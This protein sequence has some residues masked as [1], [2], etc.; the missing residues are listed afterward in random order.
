MEFDEK[1][2]DKNIAELSKVYDLIFTANVNVA[3]ISSALIDGLKVVQRRAIYS[4]YL[5]DQGKKYRKLATISGDTTGSFHPHAPTSVTDAVVGMAQDWRNS[6]PLVDGF[7]NYGSVG[8]DRAGADRYITARL[9]EYAIACFFEDW[10]DS[11]VDMELGFDEETYIPINFPAKYPN[12]LLNGCKGIGHMG[13]SC[14][15]PCFNFR[16]VVE[17]T[18]QLMNNPNSHIALIPDSPTGADIIQ[19]DF[20]KLCETGRGSYMQRCTYEI[21]DNINTITITSLPEGVFSNSVREKIADIKEKGGLNELTGMDDLTKDNVEIVLTV[22]SDVNPYKFIKKLI[23]EIPGLQQTYPIV[24]TVSNDYQTFDWSIKQLIIEWIKW[25]REQK[26]VVISNKRASLI[27]DQRTNDVKL[28]I[29]NKENLEE[30]INI[31]RTSHNRAEIEERLIKKYHNTPIQL[32]SLQARALSNMRMIEL[33][34]ESYEE[35]KKKA[36]ELKKSLEEIEEILHTEN[37]I[38]K[39]ITAEL[40]D[41][42]KR[43]GKPRKSNVIPYKISTSND[44][45][46]Y[47]IIQLS[48]D[49]NVVRKKATNAE[50]EPIPTDS[51]GFAC[52]VDN[53][54]SFI[55][56]DDTGSHTFIKVREIPLDTE[57]PV[58]RYTKKVLL[59]K[60]IALLPVDIDS[61]LCCTLVSKRGIMKRIRISEFGPSKR[62]VMSLEDDDKIVR[63]IVLKEKSNKEILIY[64]KDGIG[65]RMANSSIKISSPFAKGLNGF[66]VGKEDEIIGVYA[67]SPEQNSYLLYITAKGRMRLNLLEYLPVRNTK[68]DSL[69]Q[70]ITL[71]ERDKLVSVIGCNR[72]DK[73]QVFYDDNDSE[74]VEIEH[75]PESTMGAEP[76]KYTKKNAVSTKILKA[77]LI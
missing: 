38:D 21:D 72:Y 42:I 73:V 70:L 57:Q 44:V 28:F 52:V 55:I 51:N 50:E 23:Q 66:K 53:D 75:I 71:P 77:K 74:I 3:R 64:T 47:C 56:I 13:T 62:P 68:H 34:I 16:E 26:H 43:F 9:S 59:G 35:Y 8:G 14:N 29:M 25:R 7:G 31:F 69:V 5:K 36:E 19:T 1:F 30:T 24:I 48:S 46:G 4:M 65:Q 41:G 27:A 45:E 22:R 10:K 76:K 49:G 6:I 20:G 18:I 33:T 11:V 61:D 2:I 15:V 17:A 32:D 67:I 12:V 58:F 39:V 54:S 60:I 63:G 40:R 37:G